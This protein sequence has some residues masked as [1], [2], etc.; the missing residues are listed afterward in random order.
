[1]WFVCY[2]TL[3]YVQGKYTSTIFV[4]ALAS[5]TPC[6]LSEVLHQTQQ[7]QYLTETTVAAIH[8]LAAT[9]CKHLQLVEPLNVLFGGKQT[10]IRDSQRFLIWEKTKK[11]EAA[12]CKSKHFHKTSKKGKEKTITGKIKGNKD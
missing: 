7:A 3:L 10:Q 8:S 4:I 2:T 9:F 12:N 11:E 5:S 6:T 1:M